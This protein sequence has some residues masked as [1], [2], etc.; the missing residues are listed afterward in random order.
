MQQTR[1]DFCGFSKTGACRIRCQAWY[2]ATLQRWS[3]WPE[4]FRGS[5]IEGMRRTW[6]SQA[7]KTI[8]GFVSLNLVGQYWGSRGCAQLCK[9]TAV[10]HRS[11]WS[12]VCRVAK[13]MKLLWM[14]GA[15]GAIWQT[16]FGP[17]NQHQGTRWVTHIWHDTAVFDFFNYHIII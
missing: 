1:G 10:T 16:W 17:G 6:S 4:Q 14:A 8:P 13:S 5:V 12:A 7:I 9:E 11:K 15:F 3:W 2:I